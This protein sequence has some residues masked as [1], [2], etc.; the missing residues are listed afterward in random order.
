MNDS[1][2]IEAGGDAQAEAASKQDANAEPVRPFRLV[3]YFSFTGFIV[4]LVFTLGLT[5]FIS[6]QARSLILKKSDDYALLLADNLNHQ[7]FLQFVLPTALRYGR[8]RLRDQYQYNL[9]DAVVRNTIHSFNVQQVNIYDLEGNITYSTDQELVGTKTTDRA[10]YDLA[11]K[12]EKASR[13]ITERGEGFTG[14]FS[15]YWSLRT[16]FPFRGER[17]VKGAVGDVLGVFEIHQDLTA[18]YAENTRFQYI[19]MAISIAGAAVLFFVLRQVIVRGER[20]IDQRNEERRRLMERLHHSQRLANLGQMVAAVAHEIRNPLGIISSTGEI[21]NNKMKKYDSEDKLAGIIVEE[22]GRLNG[23]VT[24]FLDFA[25]PQVPRPADCRIED[26]LDKNLN[27]L[28][29]SLEKGNIQVECDYQGPP[30][31][32]ADPDLL[33]RAFLNV[34]VNAVQAMPEGGKIKVHTRQPYGQD[35]KNLGVVEVIISD[36]GPGLDPA[37]AEHLFTPFYTTKNRGSGLGLAIVKNIIEGH[38]GSVAIES[39][40]DGGTR[41]VLRVPVDQG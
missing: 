41:V 15:A 6:Q 11:I 19:T 1:D 3:K 32:A 27:F 30:S 22:A 36:T 37:V 29:P 31:L 12:G 24:E 26:I 16:F 5:I 39:D 18:D 35:G 25:R 20:I 33:Y 14:G 9:L 13:L 38:N 8:I 28:S 4:I 17:P 34:F 10:S 2:D 21:L 23:I 40:P 7:V